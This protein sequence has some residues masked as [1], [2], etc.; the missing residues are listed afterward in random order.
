[1]GLLRSAFNR[2]GRLLKPH[3]LVV[4]RLSR[5]TRVRCRVDVEEGTVVAGMDLD[6][7][8]RQAGRD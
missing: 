4:N 5:V 8:E 6:E 1:M 2:L 3:K 7:V